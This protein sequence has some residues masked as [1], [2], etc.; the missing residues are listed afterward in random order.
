MGIVSNTSLP[1]SWRSDAAVT[2]ISS[3]ELPKRSMY[4]GN[5]FQRSY[6]WCWR[7]LPITHDSSTACGSDVGASPHLDLT[8]VSRRCLRCEVLCFN[9][10]RE[11]NLRRFVYFLDVLRI[12]R[13]KQA[14]AT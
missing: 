10:A 3:L 14:H 4:T 7:G 8:R 2:K 5:W 6:T 12:L 11:G 9:D 13:L 1:N